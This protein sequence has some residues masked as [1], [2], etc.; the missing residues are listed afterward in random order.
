[1]ATMPRT[2]LTT[3]CLLAML[4]ALATAQAPGECLGEYRRTAAPKTLHS[5]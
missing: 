3:V 4:L 5:M 2:L 1:M